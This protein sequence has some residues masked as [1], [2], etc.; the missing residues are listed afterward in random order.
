MDNLELLMVL[1]PLKALLD[2]GMVDQAKEIIDKVIKE[3]EK[4][5]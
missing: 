5:S 1:L 4:E 3:A 2:N